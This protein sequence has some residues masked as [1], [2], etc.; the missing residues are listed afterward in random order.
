M[1]GETNLPKQFNYGLCLLHT[2]NPIWQ[3]TQQPPCTCTAHMNSTIYRI[4]R[5]N[6][7]QWAEDVEQS[8]LD[9]AEF[10]RIL[11]AYF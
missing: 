2:S 6:L 4:A 11:D 10:Q 1:Y 9:R 7:A 8:F 3:G 5:I